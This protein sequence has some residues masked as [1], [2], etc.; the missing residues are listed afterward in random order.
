M[1]DHLIRQRRKGLN[2]ASVY[3][4]HYN[5]VALQSLIKC[6]TYCYSPQLRVLHLLN[7]LLQIMRV[8]VL[9]VD[10]QDI[11]FSACNDQAAIPQEAKITSLQPTVPGNRPSG[12]NRVLVGSLCTIWSLNMNFADCKLRQRHVL[13]IANSHPAIVH[14]HAKINK[15]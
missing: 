6:S 8:Y 12:R 1:P 14:R 10:K 2:A 9:P 11:L 5:F 4:E 13:I 15:R 3:R 7:Q